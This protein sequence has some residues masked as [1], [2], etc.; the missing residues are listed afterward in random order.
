MFDD[1]SAGLFTKLGQ[2]DGVWQLSCISLIMLCRWQEGNSFSTWELESNRGHVRGAKA[3]KRTILKE[4][5]TISVWP[6]GDEHPFE[7]KA[8]RSLWDPSDFFRQR[9]IFTG[10]TV[11]WTVCRHWILYCKCVHKQI[12]NVLAAPHLQAMTKAP[13]L[14]QIWLYHSAEWLTRLMT[15]RH[16]HAHTYTH[17]LRWGCSILSK[18]DDT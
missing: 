4:C 8:S 2:E 11:I 16:A 14:V 17:T 12:V 3:L 9:P 6:A 10:D 18:S 5:I 1:F 7:P 15:H 13:L